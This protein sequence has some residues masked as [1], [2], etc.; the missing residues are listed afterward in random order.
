MMHYT[1]K[2]ITEYLQGV[3]DSVNSG[4]YRIERNRAKNRTI[5]EDF[6]FSEEDAKNILLK[7]TYLDFSY[8]RQNDN[9]R[10]PEEILYVFGKDVMLTER[11]GTN[12]INVPLYIKIN[13]L[14]DG[15][16]I[17]ISFHEQE[18]PLR[19]YFK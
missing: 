19:Y 15:Y 10:H 16:V 7:L 14:D 13:K 2:D 18:W 3:R 1:E 8:T 9:P 5:F 17:V 6:I 4:D 11:F 12:N